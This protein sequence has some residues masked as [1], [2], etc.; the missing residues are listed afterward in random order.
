MDDVTPARAIR[1]TAVPNPLWKDLLFL[2][3][4]IA[5]IAAVV[6]AMFTFLFGIIRYADPSMDPAIK[7]DDLVLYYRHVRSGYHAHDPVVVEF[8]G[9]LQVR[10]VVAVAGD[11]V[12][13]TDS[14][15]FI[16][17]S[18]QQEPQVHQPT[19]RYENGVDFPLTVPEGQVFVLGD[20][21]LG[22]TDSRIYGCVAIDDTLGK[23]MMVIRHR[24]I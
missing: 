16:N 1:P 22:A 8:E 13:I 4:K 7:D 10:R 14:G 19:E 9:H 20:A 21:R 3:I 18:L 23:V 15:L 17:G 12:D 5:A 6:L 11:V 24:G 2:L